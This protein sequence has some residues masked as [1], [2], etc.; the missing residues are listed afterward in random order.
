[1]HA[2]ACR[3][4]AAVLQQDSILDTVLDKCEVLREVMRSFAAAYSSKILPVRRVTCI[5]Q[6]ERAQVLLIEKMI[7]ADRPLMPME[8]TSGVSLSSSNTS[9]DDTTLSSI[10][11]TPTDRLDPA[12]NQLIDM[13]FSA[14]H[15]ERA[16]L[17]NSFH[18]Y[19]PQSI[20]TLV[21]WMLEHPF[22]QQLPSSSNVQSTIRQNSRLIASSRVQDRYALSPAPYY[23][24][25][26]EFGEEDDDLNPLYGE[27]SPV[28]TCELCQSTVT[29]IFKHIWVG[30]G[31]CGRPKCKKG[32]STNTDGSLTYGEISNSDKPCGSVDKISKKYILC[33][34][35]KLR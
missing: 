33:E 24:P 8:K 20:Y 12:L 21:T 34:E 31:G 9:T 15:V 11:F 6:L 1:M 16:V 2:G 35:C 23:D 5:E 30:H 4:L 13:G 3:T 7:K 14:E 10:S 29:N 28:H 19:N 17:A 26:E 27:S 22:E 18:E 32:F 25:S